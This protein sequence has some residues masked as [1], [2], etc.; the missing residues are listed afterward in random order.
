M[1]TS[2]AEKGIVWLARPA[3]ALKPGPHWQMWICAGNDLVR[4]IVDEPQFSAGVV[5]FP[6]ETDCLASWLN[7]NGFPLVGQ[8]GDQFQSPSRRLGVLRLD[9]GDCDTRLQLVVV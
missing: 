1:S 5:D 8:A 7:S 6:R 4:Q 3:N 2:V 9:C